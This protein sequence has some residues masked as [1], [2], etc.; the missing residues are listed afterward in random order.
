MMA[1]ISG[2]NLGPRTF[3]GY[4]RLP[5]VLFGVLFALTLVL[6][7]AA[8]YLGGGSRTA[9]PHLF[10]IPILMAAVRLGLLGALPAAVTAGILAGPLLPA[11]VQSGTAQEGHAWATRLVMFAVVGSVL[12][13]ITQQNRGGMLTAGQ[14]AKTAM[15]LRRALRNNQMQVHYQPLLDLRTGEAVGVEAL[16]RW[17]CPARGMVTPAEFIPAAEATGL[18]N[19]VD[20]FVL[21][22]ATAQLG[23]W[24][25]A[26]FTDLSMAVNVSASRL[27]DPGLVAETAAALAEADVDPCRLHLEITETAIIEDVAQA[28]RQIE[29]LRA[30]GVKIAL[31]DFGAGQSSMSYL[32]QFDIDIVKIDR[33]FVEHVADD[34]RVARLVAGMIRLFD[35]LGVTVV[36]EGLSTAEQY[37]HMAEL[38]C[39]IGQGFYISRPADAA[40]MTAWLRGARLRAAANHRRRR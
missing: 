39:E 7:W 30:L 8:S 38:N 40:E 29:R 14:H 5:P 36:G 12:A 25:R 26:G 13:W 4:A 31:D 22:E 33:A 10:Y 2:R 28:S 23:A 35:S 37:V 9:F 3:R 34:P 24:R 17:V 19:A 11:D 16:V 15:T 20:R 18:I 21:G 6:A 27:Q 32:N 1:F